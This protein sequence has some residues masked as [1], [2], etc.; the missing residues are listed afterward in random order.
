MI[1][2]ILKQQLYLKSC[3]YEIMLANS[4]MA[5]MTEEHKEVKE[6]LK[7]SLLACHIYHCQWLPPAENHDPWY[8]AINHIVFFWKHL[9]GHPPGQKAREVILCHQT[10]TRPSA[11]TSATNVPAVSM[12]YLLLNL[13]FMKPSHD[14]TWKDMNVGKILL[15]KEQIPQPEISLRVIGFDLTD[16]ST[17]VSQKFY[18]ICMCAS[19][20]NK[21]CESNW[22]HTQLSQIIICS[23]PWLTFCAR[24]ASTTKID[25]EA[26]VNKFFTLKV[27]NWYQHGIKELAEKWF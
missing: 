23:N 10:L 21:L 27:K 3:E 1:S 24:Y 26:S 17:R 18:N 20:W 13:C 8:L 25:V 15:N 19:F 9:Q 22:C 5:I 11:A 7:K 16:W 6:S 14:L 4:A 2:F 12:D